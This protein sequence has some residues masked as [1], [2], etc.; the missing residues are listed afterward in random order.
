MEF[1]TGLSVV[2]YF[3]ISVK[4][5]GLSRVSSLIEGRTARISIVELHLQLQSAGRGLM[6]ASLEETVNI[7]TSIILCFAAQHPCSTDLSNFSPTGYFCL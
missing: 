7:N 4:P 1:H 6:P 5:A 3:F 2:P